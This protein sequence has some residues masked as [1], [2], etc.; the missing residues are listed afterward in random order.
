[1]ALADTV[2]AQ[3]LTMI[4]KMIKIITLFVVARFFTILFPSGDEI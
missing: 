4:P 1:M 3:E 2:G